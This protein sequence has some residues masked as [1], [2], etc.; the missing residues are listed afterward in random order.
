MNAFRLLPARALLAALPLLAPACALAQGASIPPLT[1]KQVEERRKDN[2]SETAFQGATSVPGAILEGGKILT[3]KFDPGSLKQMT[4]AAEKGSDIISYSITGAKI[5]NGTVKDGWEGLARE[6]TQAVIE[7]GVDL[8]GHGAA[9]YFTGIAIGAGA[10]AGTAAGV[11]GISYTAG[12]VF[13]NYLRNNVDLGQSM[14]LR[15]TIGDEVDNLWFKATPD[16]LKELAGGTKQVNLDDPAVW[17]RMQDAADRNR[18]QATFDNVQRENLAQQQQ[19]QA[20]NVPMTGELAAAPPPPSPYDSTA[21]SIQ[22]IL[23]SVK[24]AQAAKPSM[25]T[26]REGP[27]TGGICKLDPKTGCHPG[28]NESTH[29]G[30]C[31]LC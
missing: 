19:M 5:V 3:Q 6:G 23:E 10:A 7:K 11:A 12:S 13:G 28:H 21:L 16:S 30:G 25:A 20:A 22:S 9:G 17:Q 1:A 26:P 18:R 8:A 4:H 24:A 15:G 2:A 29:P 27:S 14:G 31:K